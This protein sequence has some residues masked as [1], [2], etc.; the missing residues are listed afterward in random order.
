MTTQ[1]TCRDCH[2]PLTG[3]NAVR[4]ADCFTAYRV[5][6]RSTPGVFQARFQSTCPACNRPLAKGDNAL[7]QGGNAVHFGCTY[8]PARTRCP[9]YDP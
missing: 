1:T 2:G 3:T 5:A 7:M 4:C 9:Q 6:L 8:R